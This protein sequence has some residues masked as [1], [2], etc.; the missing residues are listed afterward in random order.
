MISSLKRRAEIR[1]WYSL[2]TAILYVQ[3]IPSSTFELIEDAERIIDFLEAYDL[4]L[5]E[6]KEIREDKDKLGIFKKMKIAPKTKS[7]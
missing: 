3:H 5:Q 6:C 7:S 1:F 4:S 2:K